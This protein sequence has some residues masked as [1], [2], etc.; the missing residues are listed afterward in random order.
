MKFQIFLIVIVL[1]PCVIA[2]AQVPETDFEIWNETT[3]AF[4]VIKQKDKTGKQFDR[5]S[6]LLLGTLRLGQNRAYPVDERIGAGFEIKLNKAFTFTPSYLYRGVQPGRRLRAFEHQLRFDLAY[7]KPWKNFAVKNRGRI[8]YRIR[9]SKPDD[10]Q[11]RH[12]LAFSMPVRRADKTIFS[13][14]I[15][16]EPFY[17]L[18][19]RGFVSNEFSAGI[20]KKFAPAFSAEFFYLLKNNHLTRPKTVN[21]VGINI[22]VRID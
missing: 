1:F 21:A 19:T 12:K 2:A 6:F 16:D 14:F 17:D 4:P 5:F 9:N 20:S 22:R 8:E 10:V 11:Y 15:A 7:D 3:I 18:T 13:P